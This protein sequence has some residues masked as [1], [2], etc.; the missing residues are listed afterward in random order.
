[1]R[2]F[3]FLVLL[4]LISCKK[5]I[6]PPVIGNITL[7]QEPDTL[8]INLD[9]STKVLIECLIEDETELSQYRI[10]SNGSIIGSPSDS[11]SFQNFVY[12][13]NNGIDLNPFMLSDSFNIQ[14]NSCT[15]LYTVKVSA[16][17]LEGNEALGEEVFLWI[18]SS[19]APFSNIT[20]PDFNS[21]SYSAGDTIFFEGT[22]TDN[23]AI[24]NI[25]LNIYDEDGVSLASEQFNYSDTVFTSWDYLNNDA[26]IELPTVLETGKY[27]LRVRVIDNDGNLSITQDSVNIN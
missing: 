26:R 22:V 24:K 11:S 6:T 7:N 1:M 2:L 17:D 9:T 21:S 23:I 25:Y 5:D 19:E 8:R 3:P 14:S 12:S 27:V 13:V 20:S 10:F 15:G 18:F 4:L 16:I